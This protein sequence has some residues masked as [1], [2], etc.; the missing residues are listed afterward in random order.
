[1]SLVSHLYPEMPGFPARVFV[2]KNVRSNTFSIRSRDK[3]FLY[4][5]VIARATYVRMS[6][7]T[8]T[9]SESGRQR[10]LRE[11]RKNVHAG[12]V[13]EV[14]SYRDIN[15][16]SYYAPLEE[17]FPDIASLRRYEVMYNPYLHSQFQTSVG[18]S[19][20]DTS[21]RRAY[22]EFSRGRS[23]ISIQL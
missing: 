18:Q 2:Y 13:G 1:M 16:T 17:S 12:V 7:V 20:R 6:N 3:D 23:R 22:L 10:V 9:V 8:F 15:G 11:Q 14:L 19:L 21:A 5:K 4:G